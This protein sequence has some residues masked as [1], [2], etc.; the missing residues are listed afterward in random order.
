MKAI[1]LDIET[2]GLDPFIHQPI[3]IA[4]KIINVSDGSVIGQYQSVIY[5]TKD[6]WKDH[7][8]VSLE[9]N[10]YSWDDISN[11]KSKSLIK[12]EII[13][14]FGQLE[15]QRGK[16][17]FVCQNPAF[18]RSFFIS[19]ID[20]YTQER[21]LWPYHWLD[22]A[23]MYWALLTK[24]QNERSEAFPEE[25]CLSKNSIAEL[26]NLPKEEHPHRAMQGVDH[27]IQCYHTVLKQGGRC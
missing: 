20:V 15:I 18:D 23:S 17:V 5:Q 11:G 24:H 7:D 14:L 6:V 3:D 27:L 2:T 8:P 19:I 9:I 22:L 12:S 26:Y 16:A 1:F 4:L 25:L 21:L 10:G 13:Q